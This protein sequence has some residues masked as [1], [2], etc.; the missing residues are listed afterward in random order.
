MPSY[1]CRGCNCKD[2]VVC[3]DKWR[4][5]FI[6]GI[7]PPRKTVFI[8]KG[9]WF[10]HYSDVIM[11]SVSSKITNLTIVYW[12]VYSG[13]DQ[14]KHQS[15]AS[16]AFVRGI[17][18]WPVNSP[19][20]GPV[21]RKMFPFDDVIMCENV[22]FQDKHVQLA[23]RIGRLSTD[24]FHYM[25]DVLICPRDSTFFGDHGIDACM[26]TWRKPWYEPRPSSVPDFDHIR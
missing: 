20:K 8:L 18:R 11:G 13:A 23:L 12:T 24:L 22:W 19:H 14:R 1:Q 6:M 7:P 3:R 17:H 15:S 4:L 10:T 5:I 9:P 25:S 2:K 21:A 16:L 26:S